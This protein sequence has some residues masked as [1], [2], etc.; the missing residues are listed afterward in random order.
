[1]GAAVAPARVGERS[2]EREEEER[3]GKEKRK[4][5]YIFGYLDSNKKRVK[6]G[7]SRRIRRKAEESASGGIRFEELWPS[8]GRSDGQENPERRGPCFSYRNQPG[9]QCMDR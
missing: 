2:R 7:R 8:D 3:S 6:Q 9:Y 4:L 5:R 1:V